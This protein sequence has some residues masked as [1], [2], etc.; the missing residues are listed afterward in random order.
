MKLVPPGYQKQARKQ[1]NICSVYDITTIK[2]SMDRLSILSGNYKKNRTIKERQLSYGF[3]H[4]RNDRNSA[5][6]H[7][8]REGKTN[9]KKSERETNHERLLTMGKKLRVA[10]GE[11]GEGMG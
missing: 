7:R 8:G 2:Q 10:G 6:D 11:V 9:G 4:M 3:T 1:I 5:Q